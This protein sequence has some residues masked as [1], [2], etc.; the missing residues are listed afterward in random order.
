MA[1]P[2]IGCSLGMVGN[3]IGSSGLS[4]VYQTYQQ[5][6]LIRGEMEPSAHLRLPRPKLLDTE[7]DKADIKRAQHPLLLVSRVYTRLRFV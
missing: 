5:V 4:S 6:Q 2:R 7:S 3:A 1:I